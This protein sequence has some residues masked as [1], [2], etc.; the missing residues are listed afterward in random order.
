[1]SDNE[2]IL[3]D[4]SEQYQ[5]TVQPLDGVHPTNKYLV[6]K[7]A[8]KPRKQLSEESKQKRRDQLVKAREAKKLKS[9]RDKQILEQYHQTQKD[10]EIARLQRKQAKHQAKKQIK[11]YEQY[12]TDDDS[13]SSDSQYSDEEQPEPI[14]KPTKRKSP[15][16]IP[17]DAVIETRS[18]KPTKKQSE[19]KLKLE[20][21]EQR[22]NDILTISK[23]NSGAKQAPRVIKKTTVIQPPPI[24]QPT[25]PMNPYFSNPKPSEET[26]NHL[27]KTLSMF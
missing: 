5:P 9:L 7:P 2:I 27:K 17:D 26:K 8:K 11:Q 15:R 23:T 14:S 21:L 12:S 19:T 3:E 10:N 16:S 6:S 1:M 22:L 20:A 25:M 24:V 13:Y 18:R 4:Y